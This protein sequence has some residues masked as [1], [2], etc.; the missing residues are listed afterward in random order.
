MDVY[1][2]VDM[3]QGLK[4]IDFV[5]EDGQ[6]TLVGFITLTDKYLTDLTALHHYMDKILEVDPRAFERWGI[7][8]DQPEDDENDQP[9]SLQQPMSFDLRVH[10]NPDEHFCVSTIDWKNFEVI[11]HWNCLGADIFD[12]F[13]SPYIFQTWLKD[14]PDGNNQIHQIKLSTQIIG[15]LADKVYQTCQE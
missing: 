13:D 2:T 4:Q 5:E 1:I 11:G 3:R 8:V 6:F 12:E 15:Q 10:S 9:A 7:T 14:D